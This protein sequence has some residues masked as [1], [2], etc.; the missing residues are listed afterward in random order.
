MMK[1]IAAIA[2]ALTVTVAIL[3]SAD[4]Q[5]HGRASSPQVAQGCDYVGADSSPTC[6]EAMMRSVRDYVARAEDACADDAVGRVLAADLQYWQDLGALAYQT[7]EAERHEIDGGRTCVVEWI[8]C[9]PSTEMIS[10]A[11]VGWI[12]GVG[13]RA[14]ATTRARQAQPGYTSAHIPDMVD[15]CKVWLS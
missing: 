15:E 13:W 11:C 3:P 6:Y 5:P 8:V 12:G 2:A 10:V 7:G 14:Q 1:A 9:C 4:A